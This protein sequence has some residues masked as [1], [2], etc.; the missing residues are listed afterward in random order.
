MGFEFSKI[1]QLTKFLGYLGLSGNSF[2]DFGTI[3][4]SK[5]LAINE[6]LGELHLASNKITNV[7]ASENFKALQINSVLT[8]LNLSKNKLGTKIAVPISKFLQLNKVI[9]DLRLASSMIDDQAGLQI[10]KATLSC[11]S[12]TSLDLCNN[13][14]TEKVGLELEKILSK[15]RHILKL[16]V[17]GTQIHHFILHSLSELCHRNFQKVIEKRNR[18]FR[19][20]LAKSQVCSGE[21][22]IKKILNHL[23][24]QHQM[25]SEQLSTYEQKLEDVKTDEDISSVQLKKL[26]KDQE[27]EIMDAKCSRKQKT[28][29]QIE[30]K[31]KFESESRR[32]QDQIASFQRKSL[33]LKERLEEKKKEIM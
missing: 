17:T 3:A 20:Q 25:L 7:G 1:L 26:I 12:L 32:L 5:S 11:S 22:E 21:L 13:F 18:V 6:S 28:S 15:N 23:L 29:Q 16:D 33:N 8:T 30:E 9:I 2:E 27:K 10:A 14:F 19:I 24:D 4:I 31:Q